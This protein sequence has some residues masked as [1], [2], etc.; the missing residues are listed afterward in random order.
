MN[1][2]PNIRENLSSLFYA[3]S[4]QWYQVCKWNRYNVWFI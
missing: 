3:Y 2:H 1:Y 4:N